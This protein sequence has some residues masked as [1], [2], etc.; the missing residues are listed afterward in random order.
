TRASARTTSH[1]MTSTTTRLPH[2][3]ANRRCST[4]W[5]TGRGSSRAALH[6]ARTAAAA[7]QAERQRDARRSAYLAL[8]EH[9][10]TAGGLYRQWHTA[11]VGRTSDVQTTEFQ[12]LRIQI[13]D[14]YHR[15][16][17]PALH[18]VRLEGPDA[19]WAAAAQVQ[20]TSTST[21]KL[22]DDALQ[23]SAVADELHHSIIA[24]WNAVDGFAVTARTAL[25][26]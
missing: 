5:V 13:R 21:F 11:A 23:T 24:F 22:L 26:P 10:H 3:H 8:I 20:S 6:Q 15:Q 16:F 17:L 1:P 2:R 14:N 4:S 19:V 18:T 25:H 7:Q 12:G 9:M